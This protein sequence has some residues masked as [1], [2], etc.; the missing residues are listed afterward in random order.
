[1]ISAWYITTLTQYKPS[2]V[3]QMGKRLR[4]KLDG[5]GIESHSMYFCVSRRPWFRRQRLTV[6]SESPRFDPGWRQ[7]FYYTMIVVLLAQWSSGLIMGL[8]I[9]DR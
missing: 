8:V 6:R 2:A 3:V 7:F 9:P 1:M 5:T 4:R